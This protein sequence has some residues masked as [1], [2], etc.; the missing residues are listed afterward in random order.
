[1]KIGDR[2]NRL[3]IIEFV[4][5]NKYNRRVFKC[6]CDCGNVKNITDSNLQYSTKSCGCLKKE[7][8]RLNFKLDDEVRLKNKKESDRKNKQKSKSKNPVEFLRKSRERLKIYRNK[9]K[10]ILANKHKN[11]LKSD[12]V[13]LIKRN[14]RNRFKQALCNNYKNGSAVNLLGI[15]IDN[16]KKYIESLFKD[17]MTWNNHGNWH[18]D[19]IIPLS[20]GDLTNLEFIKIV[21]HYTNLQPLWAIDNLKKSNKVA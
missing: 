13:Y 11:R 4:G 3:K 10:L 18:L 21:C 20:S 6:I 17:G 16:F 2:F 7:L 19:H 9:N 14:L 1:M 8:I 5:K 15:S 12:P